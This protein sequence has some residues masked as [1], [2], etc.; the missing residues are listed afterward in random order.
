M[1]SA[2]SSVDMRF[3]VRSAGFLA[4]HRL[5]IGRP[6]NH[7][8]RLATLLTLSSL[9]LL[10]SCAGS[11]DGTGSGTSAPDASG[12]DVDLGG[13]DASLDDVTEAA[14]VWAAPDA[15]SGWAAAEASTLPV[16]DAGFAIADAAPAA[17]PDAGCFASLTAGSLV[18]DEL[19][20][21]SVKGTGDH[22]EWLEVASTSPCAL[23]LNGLHGE[24]PV[25]TKLH[26]FDVTA[27]TWLLPGARFVVADD[28][29]PIINHGLPAP[30][31]VWNGQPG[32]VLRNLG[33]TVTLM[34]GDVMIDSLTYPALKLVIGASVAF[35]SGCPPEERLDFTN[36][37]TSTFSW[38][39][40]FYGTPNAPNADVQCP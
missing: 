6:M 29:D 30:V 32:D 14:A 3:R 19:M 1:D 26:T 4:A 33:G 20:I 40:G 18:I 15:P 27:D 11:L 38:F 5:L 9:S 24:C 36:W 17:R 22:G 37:Q 2:K 12:L 16:P 31:I 7:S 28:P 39:P 23:N 10:A 8:T 25:G 35:P 21:E 13:G 34:A